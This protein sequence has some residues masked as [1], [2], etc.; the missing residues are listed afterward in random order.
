LLVLLCNTVIAAD[1]AAPPLPAAPVPA[2]QQRLSA[3]EPEAQRG[4]QN[5]F[6]FT[7]TAGEPSLVPVDA[8]RLP[9]RIELAA[10]LIPEN[11]GAVAVLRLPGENAPVFVRENDLVSIVAPARPDG[12]RGEMPTEVF[13]LLIKSITS[14]GVEVAPR[15]RPDEIHLLR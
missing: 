6:T 1:A 11:G 3:T 15:V 14:T 4:G 7:T 8:G 2:L 5:P 12:R 13:Y 9:H 10:V